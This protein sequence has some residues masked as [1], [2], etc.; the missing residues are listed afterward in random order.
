MICNIDTNKNKHILLRGSNGKI[1]VHFVKCVKM[2][3]VL[4]M[5]HI[6]GC[7]E[8]ISFEIEGKDKLNIRSHK[9]KTNIYHNLFGRNQA[10]NQMV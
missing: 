2:R 7:K 10:K 4:I 3:I 9:H 1:T 5:K 6:R 8:E